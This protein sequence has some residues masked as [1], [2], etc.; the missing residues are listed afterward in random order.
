MNV[1]VIMLS[2]LV[3]WS[4]RKLSICVRAKLSNNIRDSF[5]CSSK[6]S[7]QYCKPTCHPSLF[8]YLIIYVH[9]IIQERRQRL[10]EWFCSFEIETKKNKWRWTHLNEFEVPFLASCLMAANAI[11]Y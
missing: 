6:R 11:Q 10:C 1:V 4:W 3:S 8:L 9:N 7:I 5:L 2:F